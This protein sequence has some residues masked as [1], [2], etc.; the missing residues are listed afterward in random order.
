MLKHPCILPVLAVGAW[1]HTH[2]LA[3]F[4]LSL[5]GALVTLSL[6]PSGVDD[7]ERCLVYPR[8]SGSLDYHLA[9]RGGSKPLT[10]MQ[11][12]LVAKGCAS[13]LAAMH[14]AGRVHR[15]VKS[16]N[17]LLARGTLAPLLADAG[18]S[19]TLAGSQAVSTRT[20]K[21]TFGYLCP[22]YKSSGELRPASDVYAYGVVLLEL[23]SSRP[24]WSRA[25]GGAAQAGRSPPP[26]ALVDDLRPSLATGG[27]AVPDASLPWPPLLAR[28][29]V[30]LASR[31][32]AP[33]PEARPSA[34]EAAAELA[35]L[36]PVGEPVDAAEAPAEATAA[37][38]PHEP[39]PASL[40]QPWGDAALCLACGEAPRLRRGPDALCAACSGQ[41]PDGEDSCDW[42]SPAGRRPCSDGDLDS[43]LG[44]GGGARLRLS[45]Y[46]GPV[47]AIG[48]LWEAAA[49][50]VTG[51]LA[52][53]G[54]GKWREGER[55]DAPPAGDPRVADVA[56]AALPPPDAGEACARAA[57]LRPLRDL[58][59]SRA[60]AAAEVGAAVISILAMEAGQHTALAD[61]GC[62]PPLAAL[63]RSRHGGARKRAA[64]ALANLLSTP[65]LGEAAVAVGVARGCAD[66]LRSGGGA[67]AAAARLARN[68]AAC[69]PA[70]AAALGD[71]G[72]APPLVALLTVPG[73]RAAAAAALANLRPQAR[74]EGA[75]WAAALAAAPALLGA[76]GGEEAARER[77]AGAALV[78]SLSRRS[79]AELAPAA[80]MLLAM[81][82]GSGGGG[83]RAAAAAALCNLASAGA[84]SAAEVTRVETVQALAACLGAEE[85]PL[86]AAA[87]GLAC[88]LAL[89]ARG[90]EAA[91][92][93]PLAQP[94]AAAG[95]E[96]AARALCAL[97][98]AG[99]AEA[100][101]L[102]DAG[103]QA[104]PAAEEE[105][106]LLFLLARA[107]GRASEGADERGACAVQ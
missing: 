63:L 102:C 61:A 6:H 77:A 26:R 71:S 21:G 8:A 99:S 25:R 97:A 95:G 7:R 66:M 40:A 24:S 48:G 54:K 51:W 62:L 11:R 100:A 84:L 104:A 44:S 73:S 30:R 46:S 89:R 16:A 76:S 64:G 81:L 55:R 19:R 68:L 67:A 74:G 87:A 4:L 33:S 53:L 42:A 69:G 60:P 3:H 17:I 90:G 50:G 70:C 83:E 80:T 9:C 93:A 65:Q 107:A 106:E 98:R 34:A 96:A 38:P 85:A 41:S 36:V 78:G 101:A 20:I 15:D 92:L 23:L 94:L 59:C 5:L 56:A 88:N 18:I 75:E 52:E 29:L 35:A 32:V 91:A 27:A 72:A 13:A 47:D 45:D 82:A 37:E 10:V 39:S 14:A 43:A 2:R 79:P 57:S 86:R 1:S 49:D 103:A 31:C 22:H 28:A 58:L 12:L 105:A